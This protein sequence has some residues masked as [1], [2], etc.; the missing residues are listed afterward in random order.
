LDWLQDFAA[1]PEYMVGY[2]DDQDDEFMAEMEAR[3]GSRLGSLEEPEFRD[4]VPE[5]E[6]QMLVEDGD[7]RDELP[8]VR[9]ALHLLGYDV[10]PS[11]SKV[12]DKDT[13]L[14]VWIF[15]KSRKDLTPDKIPGSRTQVALM[16]RLR[17]FRLVGR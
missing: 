1:D 8:S 4:R 7:W 16:E 17:Q 12:L 2:D 13:S 14:A 15:Q 10:P 3:Q 11:D 9:R 6:L 5:A